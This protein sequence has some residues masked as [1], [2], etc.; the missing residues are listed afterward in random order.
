MLVLFILAALAYGA[1][2]FAYGTRSIERDGDEDTGPFRYARLLLAVAAA[3]HVFA[4]GAQCVQ[5]DHPL[6]NIYLATSFGTLIAVGGYL[7]LARRGKGLDALGSVLAPVG[8]VGLALG[9]V[10]S[11][12]VVTTTLSGGGKQL[13]SAHVGLASAGLAG[14][15]L[16]SGVAG[17]YLGMERRLRRKMY[18]PGRGG[19]SLQ[20]LDRL[21][22]RLVLLVTPIFTLAIVTG[23]LWTVE[24]GGME[25]LRG[26][27]FEVAAAVVAWLTSVSLLVSRAIWGT[28]GRRSAWLTL[29]AFAAILLIVVWYGVRS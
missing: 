28:R 2:T 29:T 20:G 15:T 12:V 11:D 6:K 27:L 4:I 24:G 13:G 23:V 14:F 16:A 26:R 21:H 17:L 7:G 22:H 18:R 8:L 3:L 25:Q 19:L 1:A 5:G 10:F 9:V